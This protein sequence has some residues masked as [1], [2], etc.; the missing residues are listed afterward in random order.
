VAPSSLLAK[1]STLQYHPSATE[2]SK[3]QL[4]VSTARDSS[5]RKQKASSLRR[6]F[7]RVVIKNVRHLMLPRFD[8]LSTKLKRSFLFVCTSFLLCFGT[9]GVSGAQASAPSMSTSTVATMQV[10]RNRFSTPINQIVDN[11]V[12]DHM[13]DDDLYDP[14]ESIYREAMD[15]RIHGTY[16]K[17]IKGV[18][19]SVL[20]KD[21]I[22][23]ERSASGT[24]IGTTLVKMADFLR[25]KGFSETQ[26]IFMLAGSLVIGTPTIFFVLLLI[27]G[28][29]NKRSINRLMKKRYGET[30]TVDATIKVEE[31]VEAPD[32]NEDDDEDDEEDEDD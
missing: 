30:Y 8:H 23:A 3:I 22:K 6:Y 15:D 25:Q 12:K 16:P 10:S 31:D 20:G 13:F 29:E 14:V 28:E 9:L 21:V 1:Y 24:T 26:A 7:S 17:A 32:D 2:R 27:V 4:G 5:E 11:Y 18:T 19:L